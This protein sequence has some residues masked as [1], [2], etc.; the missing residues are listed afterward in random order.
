L[1]QLVGIGLTYGCQALLNE[2]LPIPC[3]ILMSA[4]L[5]VGV[6]MTG[7]RRVADNVHTC[8]S[9]LIPE[10]L[11]RQAAERQAKQAQQDSTD[12]DTSSYTRN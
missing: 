9:A 6:V 11:K 4:C 3:C 7:W 1:A 2:N 10:L 5:L 8:C 12:Q